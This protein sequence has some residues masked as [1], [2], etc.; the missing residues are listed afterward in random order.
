MPQ[1]PTDAK[2]STYTS[3]ISAEA[4]TGEPA[5]GSRIESL[6]SCSPLCTQSPASSPFDSFGIIKVVR[7]TI[8]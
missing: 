3:A 1:G 8:L 2:H 5:L 7:C 4:L 6:A